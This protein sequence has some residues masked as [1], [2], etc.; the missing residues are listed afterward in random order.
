M[1]L[2]EE[3]AG[4]E[5]VR[6]QVLHLLPSR[7][8]CW[9]RRTGRPGRGPRQGRGPALARVALPAP[10]LRAL[11]ER[12]TPAARGPGVNTR[13]RPGALTACS[14]VAG[15]AA[16]P[17]GAVLA[18]DPAVRSPSRHSGRGGARLLRD[19]SHAAQHLGARGEVNSR[20]RAL[21]SASAGLSQ[22]GAPAGTPGL[23]AV[24]GAVGPGP[25]GARG[26]SLHAWRV[27]CPP[28]LLPPPQGHKRP[29]PLPSLF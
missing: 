21:A 28:S 23:W 20:A 9:R 5:V 14:P 29:L 24:M 6:L 19:V 15:D 18:A 11:R 16:A 22:R 26:Q 1:R 12:H 17:G 3:L 7:R 25:A 2:K 8:L 13:G 10:G 27:P 4:T